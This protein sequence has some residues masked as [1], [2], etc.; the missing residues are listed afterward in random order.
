MCF[1]YHVMKCVCTFWFGYVIGCYGCFWRRT[2][3]YGR[4]G[5]LCLRN[6]S[7]SF[8]SFNQPSWD[9]DITT[10]PI[11]WFF[12]KCTFCFLFVLD[13][14][15]DV[16]WFPLY[17]DI[18]NSVILLCWSPTVM[19]YICRLVIAYVVKIA[20]QKRL[21]LNIWQ[22]GCCWENSLVNQIWQGTGELFF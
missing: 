6:F 5:I 22:M 17:L 8:V 14:M 9:F 15:V 16:I 2:T 20:L 1:L 7:T 13:I 18:A 10:F 11:C 3:R 12:L 19:F 4:V 21:F